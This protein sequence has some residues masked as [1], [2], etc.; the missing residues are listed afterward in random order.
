[1]LA[2]PDKGVDVSIG[3]PAVSALLIRTGKALGV[4]ADGVLSAGFS[5]HSMGVLE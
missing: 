4:S 2:I 3:D 5:P 1:M